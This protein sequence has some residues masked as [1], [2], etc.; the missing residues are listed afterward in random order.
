MFMVVTV[1]EGFV[2]QKENVP[3]M[4][5][6]SVSEWVWY[7]LYFNPTYVTAGKALMNTDQSVL[8]T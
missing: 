6:H 2:R 3:D 7:W 4:T 5:A 1:R 8:A